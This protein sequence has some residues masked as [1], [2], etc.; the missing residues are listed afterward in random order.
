MLDLADA[1]NAVDPVTVSWEATR[2]GIEADAADL[3]GGMGPFA[4]ASAREVHR[5]GLLPQVARAGQAIQA[6]AE[7][8]RSTPGL[9]LR[10]AREWLHRI[11]LD[12]RR[13]ARRLDSAV[14][15]GLGAG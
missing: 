5:Q 7:D 13:G 14:R 1:G 9:V 6:S 11:E 2:R 15:A 10:S 12:R 8:E 3:A 4:V